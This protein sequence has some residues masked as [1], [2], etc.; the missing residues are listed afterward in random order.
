MFLYALI[1]GTTAP[2][3]TVIHNLKEIFFYV[4]S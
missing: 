1:I 2:S 4:V 3:E